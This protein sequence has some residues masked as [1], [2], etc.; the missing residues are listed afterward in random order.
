[1]QARNNLILILALT[2]LAFV[3]A[4]PLEWFTLTNATGSDGEVVP[5]LVATGMN[6]SISLFYVSMPIW[7]LLVISGSALMIG[8]ANLA[9]VTTIPRVMPIALLLIPGAYY[10][11]VFFL[12]YELKPDQSATVAIGAVMAIIATVTGAVVM[13]LSRRRGIAGH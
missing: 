8:F 10:A 11:E 4:L 13:M 1:M 2:L 6:G 3:C 5:S 9:G 7:L 12:P